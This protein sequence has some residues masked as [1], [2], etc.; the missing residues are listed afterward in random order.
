M[1]ELSG[2]G[3]EGVVKPS[4]RCANNTKTSALR[5]DIPSHP[6][7]QNKTDHTGIGSLLKLSGECK[8]QNNASSTIRNVKSTYVQCTYSSPY[9]FGDKTIY[10]KKAM[11]PNTINIKYSRISVL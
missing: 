2:K 9:S 4:D 3:D 8:I 10:N 1:R 5:R 7:L 11:F 6:Y